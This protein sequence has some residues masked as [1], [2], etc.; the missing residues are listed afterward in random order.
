MPLRSIRFFSEDVPFILKDKQKI[1]LWLHTVVLGEGFRKVGELNYIFCSDDYL[2]E[3]NKEYLDHDTY[4]DIITFDTSEKEGIIAGDIYISIDRVTDNAKQFNTA[5]QTELH[6]VM[7][8]G[9]LHLIGYDDYGDEKQVM[10]AKEDFWLRK[11][12]S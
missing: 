4:T 11:L 9:V 7:V 12:W 5:V 8:H 10:T 2:L 1:R 6:R 3:I